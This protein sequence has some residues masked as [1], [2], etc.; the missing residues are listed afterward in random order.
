MPLKYGGD[1]KIFLDFPHGNVELER[2]VSKKPK[3][4]IFIK[5]FV[6]PK[7]FNVKV[8]MPYFGNYLEM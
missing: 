2:T 5:L 1:I 6:I 4:L 7:P 3:Q 8:D